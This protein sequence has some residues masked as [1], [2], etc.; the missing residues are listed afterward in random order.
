MLDE[1][2]GYVADRTRLE[3]FRTAIDR[4][5]RPGDRVVDLGC[6]TGILG[7]L[8]LRAGAS[9]VIAIDSSAMLEVA[10]RTMTRAGLADRCTF[11]HARSQ[12]VTLP[13][14][15]DV[16]ICDHVGHFGFDYG[17]VHTIGDA[18]RRFLAS[19]GRV[20]PG[21][22][23]L[24]VGA[25]ESTAA[26]A[27]VDRWN[28]QGVPEEFH[29]LRTHAANMQHAVQLA[30]GALLGAPTVIGE[31]DLGMDQG[32]FFRWSGTLHVERDGTLH[33]LAGW[34]DCELAAGVSMT[35]SP[36]SDR[37]IDRSQ[38]FLPVQE[39]VPLR[40]GDE[41]RV[42]VMARPEDHVIAWTVEIPRTGWR[43]KQATWPGMPLSS[44]D[45]AR[46][47]SEHAPMDTE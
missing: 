32:D 11:I 4:T 15:V 46:A 41:I 20:I 42:A 16:V 47:L 12:Q 26:R 24:C 27:K 34:F 45:F 8:C 44:Q 43:S 3:Q 14:P 39:S 35:N 7:L 22:L 1:H 9:H 13:D 5:L 29:W 28:A 2:F 25:I 10:R 31:I 6:G 30:Q 33:G 23:R 37:A 21:K 18:R 36:L 38:A 17:I 40:A 19:G